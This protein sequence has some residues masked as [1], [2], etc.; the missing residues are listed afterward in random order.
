MSKRE[1]E[2]NSCER[3]RVYFR[4]KVREKMEK[5]KQRKNERKVLDEKIRTKNKAGKKTVQ[6]MVTDRITV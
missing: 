1:D 6:K 5:N 2:N 4:R 3:K